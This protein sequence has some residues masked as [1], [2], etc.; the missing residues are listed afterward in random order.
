MISEKAKKEG[1]E[2]TE[3]FFGEKAKS[4]KYQETRGSVTVF[5]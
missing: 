2:E 3:S 5:K 1:E 4:F